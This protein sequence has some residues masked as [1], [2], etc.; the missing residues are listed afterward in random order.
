MAPWSILTPIESFRCTKGSLSWKQSYLD[1]FM[2]NSPKWF[3]ILFKVILFIYIPLVLFVI[4][5]CLFKRKRVCNLALSLKW[6]SFHQSL[7]FLSYRLTF[8]GFG[9]HWCPLYEKESS[10]AERKSCLKQHEGIFEYIFFVDGQISQCICLYQCYLSIIVLYKTKKST[11]H[12][13]PGHFC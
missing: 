10:T 7:V 9:H 11:G 1:D 12:F 4:H 3:W 5:S 13:L 8:F 2:N 6:L